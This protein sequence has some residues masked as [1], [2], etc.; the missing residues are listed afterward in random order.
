MEVHKNR[1]YSFA[2]EIDIENREH[3]NDLVTS[4]KLDFEVEHRMN[5]R[6]V[7][8]LVL[9]KHQNSLKEQLVQLFGTKRRSNS[10]QE[11]QWGEFSERNL[12]VPLEETLTLTK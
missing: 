7:E 5:R 2:I 6:F 3:P 11:Q 4:N 9:A 12:S 10:K 8:E 1:R